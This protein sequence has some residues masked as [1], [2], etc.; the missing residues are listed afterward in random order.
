MCLFSAGTFDETSLWVLHR[1]SLRGGSGR[2][3]SHYAAAI[4][5]LV[6]SGCFVDLN[7]VLILLC[8]LCALV[9]YSLAEL[10]LVFL[11]DG[12]YFIVVNSN[13]CFL[14]AYLLSLVQFVI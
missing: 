13:I 9:L 3:G 14:I 7:Y 6:S 12:E 11:K 1:T 10:N 2:L 5:V 4:V 8:R